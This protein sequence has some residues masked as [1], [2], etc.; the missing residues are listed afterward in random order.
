VSIVRLGNTKNNG[1]DNAGQNIVLNIGEVWAVFAHFW[2]SLRHSLSL[3]SL[4]V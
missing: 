3:D 2:W 1:A 4:S